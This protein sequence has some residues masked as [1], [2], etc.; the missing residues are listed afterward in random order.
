MN[1][2]S[3]Q[4]E[5]SGTTSVG[6]MSRIYTVPN[7]QWVV[8]N[9][10]I[11]GDTIVWLQ[12]YH[13]LQLTSRIYMYNL[14]TSH[15]ILLFNGSY[16]PWYYVYKD[17]IAWTERPS[18][19]VSK[20]FVYDVSKKTETRIATNLSLP[21]VYS[22]T[23]N[24]VLGTGNDGD[25]YTNDS[26]QC[27]MWIYSLL[28][29]NLTIIETNGTISW[30]MWIYG[31][32]VVWCEVTKMDNI[33][34]NY[35]VHLYNISSKH[36]EIIMRNVSQYM[37]KTFY[38][39]ELLCIKKLNKAP[40]S[41]YTLYTYNLVTHNRRIIYENISDYYCQPSI[42]ENRIVWGDYSYN[43]SDNSYNYK[44]ND[45]YAHNLTN[46]RTIRIKLG[47]RNHKHP[48]VFGDKIVW[49][50]D[51][52]NGICVYNLS[53]DTDMDGEPDYIDLDDDNDNYNDT[54]ESAEG[55]DPLDNT[56]T[57]KDF[58]KDF[59]PDSTDPDDDNDG[60][61]DID[62]AYPFDGTRWKKVE[63]GINW[64]M[65]SV[66]IIGCAVVIALV[67]G[68]VVRKRNQKKQA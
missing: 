11:W 60:I 42:Y 16:V 43:Y 63:V 3:A 57:P 67:V 30:D 27:K 58:D 24:W 23:D 66:V 68:F 37:I 33:Y 12:R 17:K 35:D 45:I 14:T 55:T 28:T 15:L 64:T 38:K 32:K 10:K 54:V 46:N 31:D 40:S 56:S 59:I 26:V 19:K 8:I 7:P 41:Y 50:T 1:K 4:S 49:C 9:P 5:K 13:D 20:C 52:W 44:D 48:N 53:W 29:K 39:N 22:V 61:L 36:D 21:A 47:S 18:P 62:D 2:G 51:D 25:V 34:E 6:P 65:I